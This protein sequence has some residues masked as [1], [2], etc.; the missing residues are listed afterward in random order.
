MRLSLCTVICWCVFTT[1]LPP[2]SGTTAEPNT[3][4]ENR[5]KVWVQSYIR[6]KLNN[7]SVTANLQNANIPVQPVR[8]Q[9]CHSMETLQDGDA[10]TLPPLSSSGQNVRTKRSP[11]TSGCFLVTCA[12]H[13]MVH[14]LHESWD[15]SKKTCVPLKKMTEDGYGRRRRRRSLP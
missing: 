7:S 2:V 14:R 9:G 15:Q 1:V 10:E 6:R 4:K 8:K 12:Y 13:D 11:K 3:S 5:L